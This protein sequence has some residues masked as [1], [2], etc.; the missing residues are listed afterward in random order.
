[1]ESSE[2]TNGITLPGTQKTLKPFYLPAVK[3]ATKARMCLCAFV[4]KISSLSFSPF[5]CYNVNLLNH[6][7]DD[8]A[9]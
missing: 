1:M 6:E 9:G 5:F 8:N 2:H 4:A 7:G 3:L